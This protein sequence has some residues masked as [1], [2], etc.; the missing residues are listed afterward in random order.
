M[1]KRSRKGRGAPPPR[2]SG[3]ARAVIA[4]SLAAVALAGGG[5]WWAW[6]HRE[7]TGPGTPR[8]AVDRTAADL[9]YRRFDEPTR[10]VFTLTNAGDGVLRLSGVPRVEVV[11]GC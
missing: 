10:V 5:A 6:S 7:T 11:A 8:L 3:R 1:S 2:R 9:G 4:L